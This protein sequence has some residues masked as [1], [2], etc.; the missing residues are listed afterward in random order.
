MIGYSKQIVLMLGI[1]V[2]GFTGAWWLSQA[3][4]RSAASAGA[5]SAANV[6]ANAHVTP[7][8]ADAPMLSSRVCPRCNPD[9]MRA[10]FAIA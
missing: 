6:L 9:R 10:K 3:G 7:T 2:V 4:G 1:L 8:F 5:T